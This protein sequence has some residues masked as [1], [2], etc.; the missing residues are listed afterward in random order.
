[1]FLGITLQ[2]LR[3][4]TRERSAFLAI[5]FFPCRK[6][7][8]DSSSTFPYASNSLTAETTGLSPGSPA[9]FPS[10]KSQTPIQTGKCLDR[11]NFIKT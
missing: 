9:V 6:G 10:P 8:G 5:V 2:I 7:V 11:D 3:E 1:M 4:I